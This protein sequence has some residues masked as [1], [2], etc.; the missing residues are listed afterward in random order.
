MLPHCYVNHI[1]HK[2]IMLLCPPTNIDIIYTPTSKIWILTWPQLNANVP[3]LLQSNFAVLTTYVYVEYINIQHVLC[4]SFGRF[5]HWHSQMNRQNAVFHL[6][7]T[8]LVYN[9]DYQSMYT[10]IHQVRCYDTTHVHTWQ[11]SWRNHVHDNQTCWHLL[12]S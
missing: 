6:L 3:V 4:L 7:N 9:C 1:T 5:S 2:R 10:P 11:A 12:V 8:C